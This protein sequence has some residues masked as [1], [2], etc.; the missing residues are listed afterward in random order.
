MSL[1]K[2]HYKN[3]CVW[4][5]E[6]SWGEVPYR[7]L[8]SSFFLVQSMGGALLL[9][10]FWWASSLTCCRDRLSAGMAF[11]IT[12]WIMTNR[13]VSWRKCYFLNVFLLSCCRVFPVT[14]LRWGVCGGGCEWG[15]GWGVGW[16]RTDWQLWVPLCLFCPSTI[17]L[18]THTQISIT[19][20]YKLTN[21]YIYR[22]HYEHF[23]TKTKLEGSHISTRVIGKRLFMLFQPWRSTRLY[24]RGE[25]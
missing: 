2:N 11:A 15:V 23:A 6:V 10:R 8:K 19:S 24:H 12:P 21:H 5:C 4:V 3:P 25:A 14:Y 16:R 1:C 9:E 13:E 17:H 20:L 18:G 22:Q 7:L